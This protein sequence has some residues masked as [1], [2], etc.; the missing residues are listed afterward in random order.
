MAATLTDSGEL[1]YISFGIEKVESTPDGDLMVYGRAT[2]GSVDHDQQIVHPDFSSKAIA[3]WLATGGNVRVQHNAQRDPAGIGVEAHTD[4]DGATWVKSLIVEPIAKTLVSKG[5]LRAYSVGIANPSIERDITGK[6]R[7]GIIKAG[8][9]VEISLV[10]RP[11]NAQCGFQL[12]KSASDG[13]AE[14]VGKMIGDEN[15]ITKALNSTMEKAPTSTDI[16]DFAMPKSFSID[17]TPNDLAK[18]V[19][20]KM[21]KKVIDDHYAGLAKDAAYDPFRYSTAEKRDFDPGVGG[22]VDRDQL[23]ESDFAGPHRSFPVVNQSDVSDALHLVGH[24]D[25]PAAVRA[26]IHAIARRKGFS[27]PDGDNKSV[28]E[29]EVT[30]ALAEEPAV[31]EVKTDTPDIVKDPETVIGSDGAG[32]NPAT[33]GKNVPPKPSN[34]DDNDDVEDKATGKAAAMPPK[35]GKKPAKGG[36]KLPSWLNQGD[37]DA[38]ASSKAAGCTE[39]HEHTDKCGPL[40]APGG[41]PQPETAPLP[42]LKESPA[43]PHMKGATDVLMRYKTIGMDTDLG[44]LHDFTCPAY[45]PGEVAQLFPLAGVDTLI[46]VDL[47]QRKA[48]NAATGKSLTE[49]LEAQTAWQA[50]TLLKATDPAEINQYRYEAHKAFRDAN[51]GPTSAPTPCEM[52]PGKFHRPYITDG[53]AD[54]S[55]GYGSPNG[56]ARIPDTS[57]NAHGFGRP[58]L[59]SGHQSPSPSHMKADF[60]YPTANGVPTQIRYAE[61]EKEKARRALSML[62]DHLNH[63]FPSSC[64][65]LD[66]DAY[67]QENGTN[68]APITGHTKEVQVAE[69]SEV[70]ADVYKDI[71]KL[72]A[73]VLLGEIT[74]EQA[75]AKLS[76]KAAKRYA[77]SLQKQV[78][79]GITSVDE[80]RKA[81]GIEAPAET[82]P[83]A[84]EPVVNK[85]AGANALTPDLM[86]TM[87]SEILEPLQAKITALEERNASYEEKIEA[88]NTEIN[89]YRDRLSVNDQRWDALA[90]QPDPSTAAFAGLALNN[91]AQKNAPAGIVKQAE[92]HERIQGMMMRQLERT[93]RTSENPAE[94]EAAYNALLRYKGD[95]SE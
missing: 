48:L 5:A 50:A 76:R 58:P 49:A 3:E 21:R 10:D 95:I 34:D 16:D 23:S 56:G 82:A 57:P 51:P 18:L 33:P 13:H 32:P 74:E 93:W 71:R 92:H 88:Q 24:A 70:L 73:R 69:P 1:T 84:P 64:P 65:M 44:M 80:I 22:G 45:D 89:T 9:I 53:H 30:T 15:A 27:V 12:V 85:A 35:K 4:A 31:E 46:D 83:V 63:M 37:D 11:A 41:T 79:S 90:N 68:L 14:Y 26:R 86:K 2:D 43:K 6:A 39:D 72:E 91:P 19:M 75:R 17:F 28:T 59:E 77:A 78:K 61:V 60:E 20:D 81:L 8:K 67:R 36:K 66:Q 42:E 38:P 7:G 40:P 47:W 55:S 29:P 25:D 52:G 62:H 94:R 87:M 54:L